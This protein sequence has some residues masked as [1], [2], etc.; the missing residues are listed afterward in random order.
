MHEKLA[1]RFAPLAEIRILLSPL[2]SEEH[3]AVLY[4]DTNATNDPGHRWFRGVLVR[5]AAAV[6]AETTAPDLLLR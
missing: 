3:L 2:P 4:W 6:D 5:D 1:R